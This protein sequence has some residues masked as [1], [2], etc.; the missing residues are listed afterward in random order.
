MRETHNAVSV[1][2]MPLAFWALPGCSQVLA[3]DEVFGLQ[4]VKHNDLR[5]SK[6]GLSWTYLMRKKCLAQRQGIDSDSYVP[7]LGGTKHSTLS[8]P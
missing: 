6:V 2:E 8:K 4:R 7:V 1:S 5:E 3:G